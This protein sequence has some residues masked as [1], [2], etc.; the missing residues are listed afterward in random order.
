MITLTVF[1]IVS[2]YRAEWAF[3]SETAFT[4]TALLAMVTHPAN[5]IMTI[6]PRAISSL[7]NFERVQKYLLEASNEDHRFALKN[8]EFQSFQPDARDRMP[9][10]VFEQ[11]SIQYFD[12][13]IANLRDIDLKISQGSIVMCS[14]PVGSGKTTLAKAILGEVSPS[15]GSLS[16]SRRRIGYCA[17]VPWLPSGT[18]INAICGSPPHDVQ[19]YQSVIE[20]CDLISDLGALPERDQ[21]EIGSR[22]INLSGGQRQRV[23]CFYS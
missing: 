21:T 7:A 12:T 18:I 10:V 9:E 17:Q 19:W 20:L 1:A 13:K 8:G 11:V 2:Q 23:V 15:T 22:G 6:I 4:T 16:V 5:M 14:G 3:D